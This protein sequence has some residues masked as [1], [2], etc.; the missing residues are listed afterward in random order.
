LKIKILENTYIW[1]RVVAMKKIDAMVGSKP[2]SRAR[3]PAG[4][5]AS[6]LLSALEALNTATTA[7]KHQDKV[8][9]SSD[10][11]VAQWEQEFPTGIDIDAF[12]LTIRLRRL[13]ML[14][15]EGV[16]KRGEAAGV[17]LNEVLLL[18]ALRRMAPTYSLRPTDI[19]KM[20]SVTSGTVTYRIDQL[21]KQDLAERTPD[22]DDKRG[23]LIRLTQRGRAVVDKVIVESAQ[24][25]SAYLRPL[26][27]VPGARECFVEMLRFYEQ[28]MEQ[29]K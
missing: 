5:S 14:L 9:G 8:F 27:A 3:A 29:G 7:G 13:A 19:L 17:K 15:D 10:V 6:G 25:A 23:Y 26:F 2:K 20:H 28:R 21:I 22:P 18:L 1:S 4:A 16:V 24:A 12:T 11:L